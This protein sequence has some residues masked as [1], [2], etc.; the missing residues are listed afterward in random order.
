[1]RWW[2][3]LVVGLLGMVLILLALI[4][5]TDLLVVQYREPTPAVRYTAPNATPAPPKDTIVVMTWNIKFGGARIDFFFDCYGDRVWMTKEEVLQNLA[6]L[7]RK[8][9]QVNPD[10][11]LIQEL[12]IDSKRS[13]YVDMLKYIADSSGLPYAAYASQWHVRYLPSRGL[14]KI[15]S[16]N[17]IFSRWPID[18]AYRVPLPLVKAYPW[19]YRFFYLRRNFLVARIA[20]PT[21]PNLWVINTHLEAYVPEGDNTRL[22]QIQLFQRLLD[23]LTQS[24][25]VWVAGGDLNT[26]PPGT[27][28]LKDFD[29]NAC[30]EKDPT[31][32]A[33]DYTREVEW[34][35]PLY[36]R[37]K[38]VI[39]LEVYMA[40]EADFYTHTVNG[41][42]WWNRR[43]DYLFTNA[44][45]REGLVHQ[46]STKGGMATFPLSDHAPV[47]GKLVLLRGD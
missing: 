22:I 40:R 24:G 47:T 42:G 31:F 5:G 1:M 41:R 2:L 16:G 10:I 28:K 7:L 29:D 30:K 14:G 32:V 19:W 39:P 38:E 23:S 20:L 6:G 25:V 15:N 17:A 18:T 26:V 11:L 27:K 33:D 3:R 46:D 35:R 13:A 34:L 36:Q 45:W 8:I 43:L 4:F 9:R 37:Y 12:D 44:E 21:K